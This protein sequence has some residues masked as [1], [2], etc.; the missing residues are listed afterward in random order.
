MASITTYEWREAGT[1]L[2]SSP[3]LTQDFDLGYHAVEL[4]GYG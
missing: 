4:T 3:V 1:L 2:G